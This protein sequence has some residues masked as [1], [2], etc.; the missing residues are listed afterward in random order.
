LR[1]HAGTEIN[2]SD[3]VEYYTFDVMGFLN[4]TIKFNYLEQQ[5]HP[6]LDL[7]HIAHKK[8]G[9]LNS[10]PWIKHLLMGIPFVEGL[11]YYRQFMKWSEEELDRNIKVCVRSRVS[12]SE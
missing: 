11:K 4:A 10:A 8:W 7:W 3:F 5:K 12:R 1:S 9:P 2:I 6:I